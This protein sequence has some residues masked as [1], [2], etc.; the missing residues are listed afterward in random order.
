MIRELQ[1]AQTKQIEQLKAEQSSQIEQLQADIQSKV[2]RSRDLEDQLAQ[3]IELAFTRNTREDEMLHKLEQRE[4]EMFIK[5]ETMMSKITPP[6]TGKQDMEMADTFDQI[7]E[8]EKP[9]KTPPRSNTSKESPPPKKA[10]TNSSPRRHIYSVFRNPSEKPP[11]TT[12][13]TNKTN[14]R[15]LTQP[16]DSDEDNNPPAPVANLGK[17]FE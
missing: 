14:H 8:Y 13:S 10:N 17:K 4:A 6:S 11:K 15:L 9:H 2:S 16:M 7:V 5:F 12:T 3:A 1:A